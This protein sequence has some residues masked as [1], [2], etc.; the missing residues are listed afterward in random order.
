MYCVICTQVKWMTGCQY[1]TYATLK[2]NHKA[3]TIIY[4]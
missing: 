4:Q 2:V 1:V 3:R